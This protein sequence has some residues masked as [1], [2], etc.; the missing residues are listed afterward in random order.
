MPDSPIPLIESQA[1]ARLRSAGS[2]GVCPEKD[3]VL[4][5]FLESVAKARNERRKTPKTT[6]DCIART[7]QKARKQ[8]INSSKNSKTFHSIESCKKNIIH[9]L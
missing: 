8:Y 6:E 1:S 7:I 3:Q 9:G 4:D 5:E 2:T